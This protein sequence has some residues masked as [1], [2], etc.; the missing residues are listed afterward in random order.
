MKHPMRALT[1]ALLLGLA[2]AGCD[3]GS[4]GTGITTAQGNV[5]SASNARLRT[6]ARPSTFLVRV[7]QAWKRS[8]VAVARGPLEDIR[9][10]VEGT[11]IS[12][13]T[14]PEGRFAV[15][16]DFAGPVAIV[17]DLPEGGSARLVVTVPRGG[18]VTLTNV[19]VDGPSGTATVEDQRVHFQGLVDS[20]D[21]SHQEASVVSRRTPQDGNRYTVRFDH[22]AVRD[23][24]G[25]AVD[26]AELA[27]GE[28]VDVDG[29]VGREGEVEAESVEVD[30]SQGENQNAGGN[31]NTSG[32]GGGEKGDGAAG[33]A[34]GDQG[35]NGGQGDQGG[36]SRSGQQLKRSM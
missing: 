11:G 7:W 3:G 25:A 9:V 10:R 31:G 19:H 29:E 13:L 5:A 35:G 2:V 22:A 33:G 6:P 21:C 20:T 1:L 26:C 12:A 4:S 30:E 23:R 34:R 8:G 32:S 27:P 24:S 15:S 16:G 17:F 14:D 36:G 18:S 28:S